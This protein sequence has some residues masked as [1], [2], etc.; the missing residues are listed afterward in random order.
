MFIRKLDLLS[1][2]PQIYFFQKKTN[3][4]LFGGILFIIYIIIMLIITIIYL[5][6]FILNDKYNIRYSLYKNFTVNEEEYN[7]KEDLNP[8]LNFSFDIKKVSHELEVLDVSNQFFIIDQNGNY[9]EKNKTISSTSSNMSFGIVYLCAFDCSWEGNNDINETNV[10]YT[11]TINYSGYKIDHQDEDIPL[12]RNI[13]KYI[14]NQEFFFSFSTTT[15]FNINWEI[16]KYKEES[17]LFGLFDNLIGKKNEFTSIDIASYEQTNTERVIEYDDNKFS[18]FA[19]RLLVFIKMSNKHNQYTEYVRTKKS[20]LDVFANIGALFSTLF[21]VF[22]FIF[23]FYST[24]F[25]N[26]KIVKEISS[27]SKLLKN[28]N[29]KIFRSSTIKFEDIP[30]NEKQFQ[31]DDNDILDSVKSFPS[32][33]T[34]ISESKKV[35]NDLEEHSLKKIKFIYFILENIYCKRKKMKREFKVIKICNNILSKYISIDVILHNQ[36][37]FESFLKD[38]LNNFDIIGNNILFKKLKLLIT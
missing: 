18:L 16:I 22:S 34:G 5:L 7:K 4:T 36:I 10:V 11:L 6:D 26:Y 24:N 38:Y 25:D 19:M 28:K 21:S 12:E 9:I 8:H 30:F 2:S 33:T 27:T 23:S 1:T 37:I 35:K 20:I 31:I 15:I 17:G 29:K 32:N 13:D 3:K 14:F